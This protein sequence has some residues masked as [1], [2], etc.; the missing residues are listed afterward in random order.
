MEPIGDRR[1]LLAGQQPPEVAGDPFVSL[2][3]LRELGANLFE[4]PHD[5]RVCGR[6]S[7]CRGHRFHLLSSL[8]ET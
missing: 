4:H 6:L 7:A 3:G 1:V 2:F 5:L 8:S